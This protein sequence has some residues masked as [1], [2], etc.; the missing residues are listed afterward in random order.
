MIKNILRIIF[1][2]RFFLL[3]IVYY[4]FI[5]LI[6]GYKG[7]KISLSKDTIMTDNIPSPYYFLHL[8]SKI[9]STYDF[10]N[11]IDLGCGSGR[12]INFFNKKFPD[13]NFIGIE[14]YEE[15]YKYCKK[16]F[17]NNQN[18]NL[19]NLDFTKID[20]LK[21]NSDCFFLNEPMKSQDAFTNIVNN[22]I[23]YSHKKNKILLVFL[24]CK[25]EVLKDFKNIDLINSYYINKNKGFSIYSVKK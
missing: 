16:I 6:K 4:E 10:K 23:N 15:Q 24:N 7:N 3:K 21:Y 22:I 9:I 8:I 25:Q 17:I 12:V 5:Y 2:Y 18:I 11:F 1:T 13:K 20:F 14:Y 19:I